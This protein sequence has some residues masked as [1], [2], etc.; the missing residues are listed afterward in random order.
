MREMET[1]R[2]GCRD[3]CTYILLHIVSIDEIVV[4]VQNSDAVIVLFCLLD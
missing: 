2:K 1:T 4:A 3:M